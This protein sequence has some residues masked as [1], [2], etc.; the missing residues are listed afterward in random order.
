MRTPQLDAVD[1]HVA[2]PGTPT[3]RDGSS[4]SSSTST[5]LRAQGAQT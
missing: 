4:L 1:P 2:D 3:P 5:H